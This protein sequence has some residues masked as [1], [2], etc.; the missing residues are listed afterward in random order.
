MAQALFDILLGRYEDGS[1]L[2]ERHDAESTVRSIRDHL[3]R[4]LNSRSGVLQH[5]PDY[6]MP[7]VPSLYSELPYS[8]EDFAAAVQHVITRYE[9]RLKHVQVH[10]TAQ[11]RHDCVVALE[12]VGALADGSFAQ[13]KTFFETG[14][15]A[16][17]N[18]TGV[19]G[20]H[21]R[22]L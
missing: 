1:S 2:G 15:H 10:V 4:L 17:I 11:D 9:P 3:T 21:A 19:R 18:D 13:F 14:G 5:L 8:L 16:R 22:L 6:G 12:V 7:D 20:N